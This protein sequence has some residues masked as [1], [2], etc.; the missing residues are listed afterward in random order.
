M[1]QKGTPNAKETNLKCNRMKPQKQWTIPSSSTRN[2]DR[3][4]H[5]ITSSSTHD[6]ILS[7]V[8]PFSVT[9]NQFLCHDFS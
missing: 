1:Q 2:V 6:Y 3:L 7:V 4:Q 9:T 8:N 5:A